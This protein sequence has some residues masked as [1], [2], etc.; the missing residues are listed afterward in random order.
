MRHVII[1]IV[2][3]LLVSCNKDDDPTSLPVASNFSK[4]IVDNGQFKKAKGEVFFPWGLNYTNPE[5]VGL[6]EDDWYNESIWKTIKSD[7]QE[8]KMLGANVIRIHLQYH[9][10]MLEADTPNL[11]ALG[12]LKELVDFAEEQ[13]L[14]LDI[15]GLAAYRKADQ[16][17]FYT[18]MTDH[19]RWAS[20][21]IFWTSIAETL[22][23]SKAVFTFNLINEPVVSVGCNTTSECEWTPGH[24]FGGFQFI[25]NI[26]RTTD[27]AFAPILKEWIAAM[28]QAIRSK[29]D[30]TLITVGLLDLGAYKQ[31][32]GD[33]DFLS[34]H[35]YPKSE[36]IQ[37]S[38]NSILNNQTTIPIVIEEISNL[39]CNI[40]ELEEFLIKIDG[41]YDGLLGHYHGKTIEQLDENNIKEAIQK[42][43]LQFF[44]ANNP[45]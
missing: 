22:E 20:Q 44:K 28:T 41:N 35:I 17:S 4:L 34:P 6:I 31:F 26:T 16:P 1:F 12:R 30:S 9:Q 37:N 32:T 19:E 43:F 33:L 39:N 5:V 15:T 13:Q 40:T 10:F 24:D 18:T 45:N 2:F 14:Y 42:N 8:M 27:N 23:G 36:E 21:K 3:I 38:V 25:Q 11:A 7:F 29:D